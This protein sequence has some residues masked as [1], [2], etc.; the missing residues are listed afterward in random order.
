[1]T[2][3]DTATNT[4]TDLVNVTREGNIAYCRM[5]CSL[6]ISCLVHNLCSR[7]FDSEWWFTC[8]QVIF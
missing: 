5:L 7:S 4:V 8:D 6:P 3:S 2:V 1:L